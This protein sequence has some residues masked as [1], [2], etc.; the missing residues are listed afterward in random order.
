VSAA[1]AGTTV[2]NDDGV[3]E[4]AAGKVAAGVDLAVDDN[5]AALLTGASRQTTAPK[6]ESTKKPASAARSRSAGHG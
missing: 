6:R 4:L 2:N 5:A 3:A 1:S